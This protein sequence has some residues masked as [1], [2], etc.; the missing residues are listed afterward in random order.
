MLIKSDARRLPLKDG[1]V[2]CVVTSPPYLGQRQ[3]GDD[4]NEI[5]RGDLCS[6]LDELL[7]VCREIYRVLDDQGLFWLNIGDKAVGSGGAGGDH[8]PGGRLFG[9]PRYGQVKSNMKGPQWFGVPNRVVTLLQDEGWYFRSWV[10]WNKSQ[11]KPEDK[12]HVRRPLISSEPIIMLAKRPDHRYYPE[13]AVEPGNVW[14]FPNRRNPGAK[15]HQAPFPLELPLRC[16]AVSTRPGD[17]VL[18]PFVGSGTTVDAAKMV[19]CT[20]MGVDLYA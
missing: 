10:T 5:G 6:Y 7:V 19:G 12:N 20:G 15:K 11:C 16:L 14:T 2:N 4:P 3:Y 13:N 17:V 9:I 18:D 8:N 1:S